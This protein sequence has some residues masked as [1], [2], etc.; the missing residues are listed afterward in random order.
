M[1]FL[2][3]FLIILYQP[4]KWLFYLP[5]LFINTLFFGL[6]A[7]LFSILFGQKIGSFYGGV[8]WSRLNSALVPMIVWVKGRENIDPKTSYIVLT[9]HRSAYDIFLVYGWLGIDL[10]WIMKKELKKIPGIGF[11]SK[12]VGHIFLDRT[13]SRAALE[14]LNEAKRKLVNGTSVVIFPEGTRSKSGELGTFK[15]GAFKL[16]LDL[17]LPI[18]P[19]TLIGTQN[20]LPTDSMNILPGKVGMVIHPPM[21]INGYS[22][23][24][25][26]DL[27]YE[28]R[29]KI[30]SALIQ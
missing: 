15:R 22:E 16:A 17:D 3:K 21:N 27:I 12:K 10:K 14:S 19:V 2:R 26:N 28:V 20:I 8:I 7:V 6:T 30:A 24:N 25:M 4:Y 5:F 11:G 23:E 9:N 29:K 1:H 18:L 13:N